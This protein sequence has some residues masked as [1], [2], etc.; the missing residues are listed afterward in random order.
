MFKDICFILPL[1]LWTSV[2]L[3]TIWS[4][5]GFKWFMLIVITSDTAMATSSTPVKRESTLPGWT[6]LLQ[7]SRAQSN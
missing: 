2:F 6:L 5:G 7:W 4:L 3:G 1:T